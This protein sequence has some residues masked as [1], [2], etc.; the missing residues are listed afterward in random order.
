MVGGCAFSVSHGTF[1][2][3]FPSRSRNVSVL[4]DSRLPDFHS[5]SR[6]QDTRADDRDDTDDSKRSPD[7]LSFT[8]YGDETKLEQNILWGK[9]K[10]EETT[11]MP[12]C[13]CKSKIKL[14]DSPIKK[15]WMA[16]RVAKA[17]LE[18]DLEVLSKQSKT[19]WLKLGH[20]LRELEDQIDHFEDEAR[21]PHILP[22]EDFLSNVQI[23]EKVSASG[24]KDKDWSFL[25]KKSKCLQFPCVKPDEYHTIGFR[26]D[27]PDYRWIS[28]E[29][30]LNMK[31]P[32]RPYLSYR[33][34]FLRKEWLKNR[35]RNS[36]RRPEPWEINYGKP[37]PNR[38]F[39]LP[40]RLIPNVAACPRLFSYLQ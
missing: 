22:V 12:Y 39:K 34:E 10:H 27:L 19:R 6:I 4:M 7:K 25:C 16:N 3:Q 35:H 37:P 28:W 11:K 23:E 30:F 26:P 14:N 2:K 9:E 32:P 18:L 20:V 21:K 33:E 17:K 40:V 1:S 31:N 38:L 5:Y 8:G 24:W 15:T 13:S 29:E 36:K